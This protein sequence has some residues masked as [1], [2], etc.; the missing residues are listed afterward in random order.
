MPSPLTLAYQDCRL[1]A[2]RAWRPLLVLFSAA[3]IRPLAVRAPPLCASNSVDHVPPA[4]GPESLNRITAWNLASKLRTRLQLHGTGAQPEGSRQHDGSVDLLLTGCEVSLWLA[5]Q[6]AADLHL[7]FPRLKV[8]VLV[9]LI[10]TD[11]TDGT[12][13]ADCSDC[14]D[15]ALRVPAPE[16]IVAISANKLLGQLGQQYPMPQLGF[17]FNQQTFSLRDSVV[18]VLSHSGGTFGSLACS[19]LLRG[20]TSHIFAITSEWD[21]QVARAVRGGSALQSENI[22][23][24]F[25]GFRPAEPCSLSLVAMHH[26]LSHLLIFFLGYIAHLDGDG[27]IGGTAFTMEEV[28]ALGWEEGSALARTQ[29]PLLFAHHACL[30]PHHSPCNAHT[31]LNTRYSPLTTIHQSTPKPA[32]TPSPDPN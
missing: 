17:S 5:E 3:D 13:R 6:L 22:F 1:R 7:A 8:I 19:N 31:T 29:E 26:L 15:A 9:V 24:T 4:P 28:T 20:W 27:G 10:R 12:D 18:V 23:S 32:P 2:T 11:G 25:A 21:T 30:T 16:K 14:T